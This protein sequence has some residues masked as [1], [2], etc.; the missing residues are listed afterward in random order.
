MW[1]INGQRY[2]WP[3]KLSEGTVYDVVY[4]YHRY[5]ARNCGTIAVWVNGG[6]VMDSPCWTYMGTTNGSTQGLLFWDG[7]TYLQSGL[8]A[9]S[10]YTLFTQ[11]T[12]YPIGAAATNP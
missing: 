7:A 3:E 10:V 2:S 4:R 5:S 8:A 9:L 1:I 11:A 12:N 6:K